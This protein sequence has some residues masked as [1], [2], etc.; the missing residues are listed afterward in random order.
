[1]PQ[2][3]EPR[4]NQKIR[5][6]RDNWQE[7]NRTL[8]SIRRAELNSLANRNRQPC[9]AKPAMMGTARP[10][11]SAGYRQRPN[12]QLAMNISWQREGTN[13]I[14]KEDRCPAPWRYDEESPGDSSASISSA[15]PW[16]YDE[17]YPRQ[18]L[19]LPWTASTSTS[20]SLETRDSERVTAPL[21]QKKIDASS[22]QVMALTTDQLVVNAAT[23]ET[24]ETQPKPKNPAGVDK[25]KGRGK[26]TPIGDEQ[27][28]MWQTQL[29]DSCRGTP[30][31]PREDP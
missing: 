10:R 6:N 7:N 20:E 22:R 13:F 16:R 1:M 31:A 26:K 4:D 23:N 18:S 29:R 9:V 3:R 14:R 19:G 2:C 15:V 11:L 5:Y 17:S 28:R 21:D 25:G 24:E 12:D 30:I 27:L 8:M